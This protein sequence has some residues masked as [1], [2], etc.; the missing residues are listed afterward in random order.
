MGTDDWKPKPI[1]NV[2]SRSRSADV[3]EEYQAHGSVV[4]LPRDKIKLAF[5]Q[6]IKF[7]SVAKALAAYEKSL[8]E[9]AGVVRADADV[10]LALLEHQ[11]VQRLLQDAE[12][13]HKA[14][15]LGR[16][17]KLSE[18]IDAAEDADFQL[19]LNRHERA[20]KLARLRGETD[21]QREP[22]QPPPT[23]PVDPEEPQPYV[24]TQGEREI[25]KDAIAAIVKLEIDRKGGEENLDDEDR[26]RI[27]DIKDV[28][29]EILRDSGLA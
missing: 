14:D 9:K 5:Y 12:T 15:A 29:R 8:R 7:H 3:S 10:G 6:A 20:R 13:I 26:K 2:M 1:T 27:D 18:S 23:S 25:L 4:G 28:G 22:P 17:Q 19:E 11:R 21:E 16:N 24:R